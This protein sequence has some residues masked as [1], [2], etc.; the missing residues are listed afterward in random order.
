MTESALLN[1]LAWARHGHKSFPLHWP[2][3]HNGQTVCSCGRLC[4]K[5][6]AKHPYSVRGFAPHGHLDATLNP[7]LIELEEKL[8]EEKSVTGRA[9]F[10]RLFDETVAGLRF[11]F[12][13]AG[14]VE[15]LTMQE[16][17]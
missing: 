3:T 7:R 6:A 16:I 10:V 1:A 2:V 14:R 5:Q 11:P 9:A 12:E 17:N 8:L 13:H 15:T 4:G